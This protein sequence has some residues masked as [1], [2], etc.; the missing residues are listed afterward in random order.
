[1]KKGLNSQ[2]HFLIIL[3]VSL[4]LFGFLAT[5]PKTII[6]DDIE[7]ISNASS[8]SGATEDTHTA[9]PEANKLADEI[10]QRYATDAN[11][12]NGYRALAEMFYNSS[13]FDSSA[14]YFEQ[15]ALHNPGI[16]NW[17]MAGD[18]YLQAASLAF[19]PVE[20][21]KMATKSREAYSNVLR[22][23]PNNLYA[24]TNSALTFV[25]SDTPMRA[26]NVLREVLDQNPQYVPAILSMAKLSL[27]SFQYDKA[28]ER[29]VEVLKLDPTN[30]DA[31]IGLGY[32]Y[33]ELNKVEEGRALLAEV[34]EDDNIDLIIKQEVQKT[35]NNL[36]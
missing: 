32:S 27:Q 21:D 1:M 29:F 28:A 3:G 8:E 11:P 10:R 25:D 23:D 30:L 18:A 24:K 35:L 26:I 17:T 9:N 36:K 13:M 5:R 12:I 4:L 15:I 6:N 22:M 19:N 14:Y 31:K 33:L 2:V 34:V 20:I 16:Q 7:A